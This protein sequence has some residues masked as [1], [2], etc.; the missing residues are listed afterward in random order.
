MPTHAHLLN[1]VPLKASSGLRRGS[2]GHIN[3]QSLN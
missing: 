1:A 3:E 2:D